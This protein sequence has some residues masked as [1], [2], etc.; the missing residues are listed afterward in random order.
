MSEVQKYKRNMLLANSEQGISLGK[1]DELAE[2]ERDTVPMHQTSN[3]LD[4]CVLEKW[5]HPF[6]LYWSHI[7]PR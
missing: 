5:Y 1:K 7:T 3:L 4:H 2:L 6:I